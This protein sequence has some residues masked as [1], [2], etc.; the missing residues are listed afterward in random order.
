M[1]DHLGA[2]L[3]NQHHEL[4]LLSRG[5]ATDLLP[6]IM[7]FGRD[8]FAPTQF[9]AA[10]AAFNERS[11]RLCVAAGFQIVRRFEGPDGEFLELQRPA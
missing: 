5:V 3:G 4:D 8:R 11:K 10:V 6:L 1:N 7:N 2:F 9:R